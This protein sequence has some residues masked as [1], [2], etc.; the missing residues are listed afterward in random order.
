[1]SGI[2]SEVEPGREERLELGKRQAKSLFM[3]AWSSLAKVG[4]DLLFDQVNRRS[5]SGSSARASPSIKELNLS[6]SLQL[7]LGLF[8]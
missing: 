5:R 6:A 4:E 7:K 8:C 3:K 1:M 2:W